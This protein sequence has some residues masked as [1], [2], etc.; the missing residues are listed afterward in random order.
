MI[1]HNLEVIQRGWLI[2]ELPDCFVFS[3]GGQVAEFLEPGQDARD[4][5]LHALPVSFDDQ[6]GVQRLFIR[7]IHAGEALDLAFLGQLVETFD[8]TLATDIDG[9]LHIDLDEVADVGACPVARLAVGGDGGG[10]ACYS[11]AGEQ[12]ADESDTLDIG[13]PVFFTET[14]PFAEMSAH[15]I[16]IQNLDVATSLLQPKLDDIGKRTLACP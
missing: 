5:L 3:F 4:A 9:A 11:V 12:A 10:D 16:T 8:I 7:V 14:Q 1:A 6:F 2:H 13:I 15:Y